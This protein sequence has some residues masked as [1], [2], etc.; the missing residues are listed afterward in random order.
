MSGETADYISGANAWPVMPRAAPGIPAN[1]FAAV[2]HWIIRF[3]RIMTARRIG[4]A[5]EL[6][7]TRGTRNAR[8][9]RAVAGGD[10]PFR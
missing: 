9:L 3:A 5:I 10:S 8:Q 1:A 4:D 6:R 2:D 7:Q